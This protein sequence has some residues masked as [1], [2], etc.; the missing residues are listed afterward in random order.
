M[1]KILGSDY[2]SKFFVFCSVDYEKSTLKFAV[3]CKDQSGLPATCN[4]FNLC[5]MW[6]CHLTFIWF[7]KR[8]N[9][10]SHDAKSQ[11]I[12]PL[13]SVWTL[14]WLLSDLGVNWLYFLQGN[15]KEQEAGIL[16]EYSSNKIRKTQN[17]HLIIVFQNLKSWI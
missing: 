1:V 10:K 12:K 5:G 2:F 11:E 13:N 17:E 16:N 4:I 3:K 8:L 9:S 6:L 15:K 7:S 14:K